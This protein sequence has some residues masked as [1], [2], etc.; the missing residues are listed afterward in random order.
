MAGPSALDVKWSWSK[1]H[2]LRDSTWLEGTF[3]QPVILLQSPAASCF[4]VAERSIDMV[5][6]YTAQFALPG[7][8]Y[9]MLCMASHSLTSTARIKLL[10][11]LSQLIHGGLS[12]RWDALI[13]PL[14]HLRAHVNQANFGV[15]LR[16]SRNRPNGFVDVVLCQCPRLFNA[17]A[18][19]DES[20]CLGREMVRS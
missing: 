6:S 17:I 16:E 13:P 15:A 7:S 4:N 19:N 8:N 3:I 2:P 1:L 20:S 9:S 12:V 5:W 11:S 18:L 10:P 14:H